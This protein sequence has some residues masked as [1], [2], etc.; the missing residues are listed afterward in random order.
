MDAVLIN[1]SFFATVR[2]RFWLVV[3]TARQK[4]PS[5][6]GQAWM[7]GLALPAHGLSEKEGYRKSA[8][9]RTRV[10]TNDTR[11]LAGDAFGCW[12]SLSEAYRPVTAAF[13][14][15]YC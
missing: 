1:I 4:S 5:D 3:V 8:C 14:H 13:A 10:E 7:A 6:E 11:E 2:N 12:K 9:F 15:Y